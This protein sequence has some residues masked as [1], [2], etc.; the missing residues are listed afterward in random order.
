M[1]L[2]RE[3]F[4]ESPLLVNGLD[5]M[6]DALTDGRRIR[7]LTVI[8][9]Y[10][11][12]CLRISVDT[13]INASKVTEVLNELIDRNGKPK[14]VIS[15]NG[16]KFT[17]SVVLKWS[18]DQEIDWQYIEPGKPYQNGNIESFNGKLRD[19]CLNENWLLNLS[20]ARRIVGKWAHEYN[21]YRPHS[22][23]GGLT[24]RELAS[25]LR[26]NLLSAKKASKLTG[27]SN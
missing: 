2:A 11:R 25:Q 9:T 15:D 3:E 22:A 23:L 10:T 7:L 1:P 21:T 14:T 4:R 13:S 5:F 19:E 16:T 12:E 6:H 26:V 20:D 18:S 8:D 27:T 24:P 17:S